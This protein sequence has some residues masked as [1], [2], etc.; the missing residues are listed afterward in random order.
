MR[1]AI[2]RAKCSFSISC[3]SV[4]STAL[5]GPPPGPKSRPGA[6]VPR[7]RA[8]GNF[9]DHRL[10]HPQIKEIGVSVIRQEKRAPA[11]ADQYPRAIVH[12]DVAH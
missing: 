12:Y 1:C 3:Q 9:L 2:W 8:A 5:R 4:D 6:S 7:S 11:V 10:E